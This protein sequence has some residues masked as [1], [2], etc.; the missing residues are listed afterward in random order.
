MD[1][2]TRVPAERNSLIWPL[3]LN[4][5]L[6]SCYVWIAEKFGGTIELSTQY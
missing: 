6:F 1:W 2:E 4:V 5:K 3:P